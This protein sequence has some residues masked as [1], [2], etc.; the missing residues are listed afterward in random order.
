MTKSA[1]LKSEDI[2]KL[3]LR[4]NRIEKHSEEDVFSFVPCPLL[5]NVIEKVKRKEKQLPNEIISGIDNLLGSSV[6]PIELTP[7]GLCQAIDD[8]DF[9]N[10]YFNRQSNPFKFS[11]EASIYGDECWGDRTE[12]LESL[13]QLSWL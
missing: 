10:K 8:E 7:N 12:L 13:R 4:D 9:A 11:T 2:K 5:I 3:V 1:I 6:Y